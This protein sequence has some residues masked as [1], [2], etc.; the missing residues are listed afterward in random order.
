MPAFGDMFATVDVSMLLLATVTGYVLGAL[1]LADRVSRRRGVNIFLSGTR[2]AGSSNVL[3]TVGKLPAAIVVLGDTAKG[4]V[5]I[6]IAQSMGIEGPWLVVPASAAV[7]GHWHSIFTRLKGGDAL[8]TFGGSTLAVFAGYGFAGVAF[9]SLMTVGAK[10]MPFPLP[11]ASLFSIIFGYTMIVLLSVLN[12]TEM[13]VVV[14]FSA[15]AV[16]V[17]ARA[18]LGHALRRRADDVP[19]DVASESIGS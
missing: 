15:L 13:K 12:Y 4:V 14:A 3:K 19:D 5:A 11:F 2:L 6:F 9:A 1:P 10:K 8:V 18:L 17:F 16:I 7:L